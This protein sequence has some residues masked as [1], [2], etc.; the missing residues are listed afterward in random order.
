MDSSYIYINKDLHR[1]SNTASLNLIFYK[2]IELDVYEKLFINSNLNLYL[3][4]F[5][6]PVSEAILE[7][8]LWMTNEL[9]ANQQEVSRYIQ[10]T[11]KLIH[12]SDMDFYTASYLLSFS[13]KFL[14]H[15]ENFGM[16]GKNQDLN[17]N[18]NNNNLE[19]HDENYNNNKLIKIIR[20]EMKK[21]E[22][23][24]EKIR[25]KLLGTIQGLG[26]NVE[27][28]NFFVN[29]LEIYLEEIRTNVNE[30][31]SEYLWNQKIEADNEDG[32]EKDKLNL[33][34]RELVKDPW[35][36]N[37]KTE[38]RLV[39]FEMISG[40][41][42]KWLSKEDFEEKRKTLNFIN[43]VLKQGL[44]EGLPRKG[45]TMEMRYFKNLTYGDL[46]ETYI[47]MIS[48]NLDQKTMNIKLG[49]ISN[50][51]TMT[52]N[53]IILGCLN[54]WDKKL[55]LDRQLE[56]GWGIFEKTISNLGDQELINLAKITFRILALL[57][58]H[59]SKCVYKQCE[60]LAKQNYVALI[61][62][63]LINWLSTFL[64][65][66]YESLDTIL[67]DDV[68]NGKPIKNLDVNK[69][70]WNNE[71]KEVFCMETLKEFDPEIM[72]YASE[73]LDKHTIGKNTKDHYEVNLIKKEWSKI[74]NNRKEWKIIPHDNN[75]EIKNFALFLN[76][77]NLL[78]WNCYKCHNRHLP[79]EAC[80]SECKLCL[81]NHES[82]K[83]ARTTNYYQ[84]ILADESR[85]ENSLI[86]T[87]I[88]ESANKDMLLEFLNQVNK[89]VMMWE[90]GFKIGNNRDLHVS[91]IAYLCKAKAMPMA[92]IYDSIW[93]LM[94]YLSKETSESNAYWISIL[95]QAKKIFENGIIS[96]RLLFESVKEE[97]K[98]RLK[99][100]NI[101]Q[102]YKLIESVKRKSTNVLCDALGE[103]I[104]SLSNFSI[105]FSLNQSVSILMS[106]NRRKKD[107]EIECDR[108][109][110]IIETEICTGIFNESPMVLERLEKEMEFTFDNDFRASLIYRMN[111]AID[112][113]EKMNIIKKRDKK[114]SLENIHKMK[115]EST[116]KLD[117]ENIPEI[118]D[119]FKKSIIDSPEKIRNNLK[120]NKDQDFAWTS[121]D[122]SSMKPR[123]NILAQ[124]NMEN[125][126]ELNNNNKNR[127]EEKKETTLSQS[128]EISVKKSIGMNK[129]DDQ[130]TEPQSLLKK[131]RRMKDLRELNPILENNPMVQKRSGIKKRKPPDDL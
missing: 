11:K 69:K 52:F 40:D 38:T 79:K 96:F 105:P 85:I 12:P 36:L 20:N 31:Y 25:T 23:N 94:D 73:Y 34:I 131:R 39:N 64:I 7:K 116:P 48:K 55:K 14:N 130:Q 93:V 4:A 106:Q 8:K 63:K 56:T 71:L 61:K 58:L 24:Q 100:D 81:E 47:A 107:G 78:R 101:S 119:S 84:S 2:A 43:F 110:R 29:S 117:L 128:S 13:K 46:M 120:P 1:R 22:S 67:L 57:N 45:I 90:K 3:A 104:E 118:E 125:A 129:I 88:R 115:L 35:T 32:K 122:G 121:N 124:D 91:L 103:K 6:L 97:Q 60:I 92:N 70:N 74:H 76:A 95:T 49:G 98:D 21:M 50:P 59:T 113:L 19:H 111:N 54:E 44:P 27:L 18:Q 68:W 83:C 127:E 41:K 10:N 9:I 5:R 108:L 109:L 126:L 17:L 66:T 28:R 51:M 62:Q 26:S 99:Q 82:S 80:P 114:N 30:L 16:C 53:A 102:G 87:R 77:A 72:N 33:N 123:E 65:N 75:P 86:P 37:L 112:H 42:L 89:A 15:I